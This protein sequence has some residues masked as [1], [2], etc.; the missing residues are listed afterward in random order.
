MFSNESTKLNRD[1]H[2]RAKLGIMSVRPTGYTSLACQWHSIQHKH[3]NSDARAD[4]H[5]R[6]QDRH[7]STHQRYPLSRTTLVPIRRSLPCRWTSTPAPSS[8]R[9]STQLH[10][11]DRS[12]ARTASSFGWSA[13]SNVEEIQ[14]RAHRVHARLKDS[15][16]G[17]AETI[18]WM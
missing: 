14:D 10:R 6:V 17:S 13:L 18:T 4:S 2:V 11:A 1:L 15:V 9:P 5:A 12:R 8:L 3:S 16:D 7:F